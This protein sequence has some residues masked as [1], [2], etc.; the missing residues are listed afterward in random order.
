MALLPQE[1][2]QAKRDG[3]VLEGDA[4]RGFVAGIAEG[5]VGE[6]QMAAFA[7]SVLLNGM[8]RRETVGLTLAMRDTGDVL[9]WPG[10]DGPVLDKHS[11]GGIGDKTSL[12]LAP[13]LAACGAYVP[14]LSGRGLGHTGGTLDKLE[15]F[16][17][18]EVAPGRKRL[19]AV[20]ARA[21]CAIVGAGAGAGLA[22]AD[23]RLYAVRDVTATV[24]SVPLIVASILSKKLAAG[25]ERLIMDVKCGSGAFLAE[26]DRARE[27]ALTLVGVAAEA[28]LLCRALVTDMGWCLGTTAG[29]ALEVAEAV[30]VLRGEPADP[31]LWDLVL[32]LGA[33]ALCMGGLA[34]GADEARARLGHVLATGAAA[35]RFG[36]MVRNLGGPDPFDWMPPEAPVV[37]PVPAPATGRL[38]ACDARALGMAVVRL[39]GGRVRPSAA[40]DHAV[41]LSRVRSLGSVVRDEPLALIHARDEASAEAALGFVRAA[42][43]IGPDDANAA[44][45]P[46]VRERVA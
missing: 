4:I 17:G 19:R 33:E 1:V 10:L 7:M 42:Y 46:I 21:G 28:G 35:E 29:N 41:G 2:I 8:D 31:R 23:A 32:A 37:R 9:T 18:Y 5:T 20:V 11:T 39:G 27:L 13:L 44:D 24:E 25:P 34:A 6:A 16:E 45:P 22:P 40:I 36:R 30:A 38:L 12:I 15:S 43:E 26:I 14:M 3:R